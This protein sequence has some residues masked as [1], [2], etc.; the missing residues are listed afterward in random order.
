MTVTG[1]TLNY[2][3]STV[4]SDILFTVIDFQNQDLY[5]LIKDNIIG[6]PSTIFCRYQGAN[7][8]KLRELEYGHKAKICKSFLRNDSNALYLWA[9]MQDMPTFYFI[10]YKES[11]NFKPIVSQKYGHLARK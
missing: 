10:W 7:V 11:N 8:T 2:L 9:I 1:L 4:N 3:L 5:Q 6:G